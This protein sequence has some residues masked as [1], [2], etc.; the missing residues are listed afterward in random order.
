M[1]YEVVEFNAATFAI[2]RMIQHTSSIINYTKK[3]NL[4]NEECI[5]NCVAGIWQN[6]Y[7]TN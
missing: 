7:S 3:I 1:S 6:R 4:T 5:T 2:E